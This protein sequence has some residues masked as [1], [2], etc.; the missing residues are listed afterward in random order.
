MPSTPA[1]G[2]PSSF[3]E[4]KGPFALVWGD[5]DAPYVVVGSGRGPRDLAQACLG[6]IPGPRRGSRVAIFEFS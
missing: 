2:A 1:V 6:Q 4:W 3:P 5:I